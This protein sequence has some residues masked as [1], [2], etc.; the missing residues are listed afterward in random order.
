[1]SRER[2]RSERRRARVRR[3]LKAAAGGRPRLSVFRSSQHIYA[4]VIDDASG[5]TVASA[6]T[7]EKDLRADLKTGADAA[8]AARVG[9]LIAER[10]TAAGVSKVIFDRGGRLYHGR[11][12]ALA[13]AA[14]EGGLDF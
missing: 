2:I 3:H 14:R 12:K 4:Q 9:T 5:H 7:L 10:A 1:M 8:A 11:L 6:S 13:D